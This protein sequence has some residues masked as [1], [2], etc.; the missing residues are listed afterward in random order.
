M[1]HE[2]FIPSANHQAGGPEFVTPGSPLP[3]PLPFPGVFLLR[4]RNTF[5]ETSIPNYVSQIP[6]S[7]SSA[8]CPIRSAMFPASFRDVST[9]ASQ[10]C[11][12]LP[13]TNEL[14]HSGF[15]LCLLRQSGAPLGMDA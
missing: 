7:T 12:P 14:L 8:S 1:D 6:I 3:P 2:P 9:L 5:T 13:V 4:G 15:S 10:S 11:I